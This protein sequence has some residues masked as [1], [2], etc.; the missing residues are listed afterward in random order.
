MHLNYSKFCLTFKAAS[1]VSPFCIK[2]LGVKTSFEMIGWLVLETRAKCH[3][4]NWENG[5]ARRN[6]SKRRSVAIYFTFC[7]LW[8]ENAGNVW[9][10]I[11][12]L[13]LHRHVRVSYVWF[14]RITSSL[15]CQMQLAKL[16][17]RH[18]LL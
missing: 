1:S 15:V 11:G 2:Y 13:N 17:W 10:I 3:N 16:F 8:H 14:F 18:I 5:V 6:S 7:K 9:K 12:F 4:Y